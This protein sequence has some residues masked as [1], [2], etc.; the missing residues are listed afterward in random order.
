VKFMNEL[1]LATT[2]T[3]ALE[4]AI[5]DGFGLQVNR[6]DLFVTN[7]LS[8]QMRSHTDY[9]GPSRR[10]AVSISKF[11]YMI[12]YFI[13]SDQSENTSNRIWYMV[14]FTS[15]IFPLTPLL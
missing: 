4:A 9:I 6:S 8:V 10:Y 2:E 15:S 12:R 3:K 11:W 14:P 13:R 1:K 7:Y 5:E